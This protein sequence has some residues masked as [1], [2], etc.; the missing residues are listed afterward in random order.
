MFF[1]H[2]NEWRVVSIE[3]SLR[4]SKIAQQE[5]VFFFHLGKCVALLGLDNHSE[6]AVTSYTNKIL[7]SKSIRKG[8]LVTIK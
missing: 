4:K 6:I 3:T 1:I 2:R 5:I 7:L 8:G